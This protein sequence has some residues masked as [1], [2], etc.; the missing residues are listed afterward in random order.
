MAVLSLYLIFP[1]L[2]RQMTYS[3]KNNIKKPCRRKTFSMELR[4]IEPLSESPSIK[5]SSITVARLTFPYNTAEQQAL[6]L[7]SFI[8]LPF[9]QSFGN[10]VP[11]KVDAE[12]LSSE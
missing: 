2:Y 8:I 12:L 6:L 10:E 7:S 3:N 1:V 5:A 11:R 9:P 4:G